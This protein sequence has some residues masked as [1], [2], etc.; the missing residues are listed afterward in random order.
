MTSDPTCV[1]V[2]DLIDYWTGEL[3]DSEA[4]RVE[5]HVFACSECA[6][7]LS[8]IAAL[9][10][11]VAAAMKGS[12]IQTVITESVLNTL[13]RAGMRIR[14]YTLLSEQTVPCAVWP[15]DDIVVTRL[16]ADFTGFEHVTMAREQ[17]GAQPVRFDDIAVPNGPGEILA[18]IPASRLRQLST[19]RIQLT[20][21]GTRGGREQVIGVYGLEHS[22]IPL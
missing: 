11:G 19:C 14:G 2:G 12:R 1:A 8:E 20:V 18:I 13:Q 22:A 9:G 15:D 5:E 7:R 6:D 17:E 16:R 10:D 21:T 3:S 4:A